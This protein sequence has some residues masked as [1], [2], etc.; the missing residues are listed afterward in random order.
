MGYVEQNPLKYIDPMGLVRPYDETYIGT[1]ENCS[2]YT[3]GGTLS[4]ICQN[5]YL[6]FDDPWGNCSRKCVKDYYPGRYGGPWY[7]HLFWYFFKHP[8]CWWECVDDDEDQCLT[9]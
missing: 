2:H 6:D 4:K 7:E 3:P 5:K 9:E 8:A 1:P